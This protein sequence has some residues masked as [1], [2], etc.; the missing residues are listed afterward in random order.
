MKVNLGIQ[1]K[2]YSVLNNQGWAVIIHELTVLRK[3]TGPE[4]TIK[5]VVNVEV[6]DFSYT[7]FINLL[8]DL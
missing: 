4:K 7:C 8:I 3:E 2:S 6:V 1:I 5:I